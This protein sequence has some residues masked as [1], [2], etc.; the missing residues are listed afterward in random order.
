MSE[1]TPQEPV[2][3]QTPQE[4]TKSWVNEDGTWNRDAM[5]ELGQHSI[6]E[7]YATAEELIKGTINKDQVLGK[8]IDDI[9]SSDDEGIQ[10]RLKEIRG[11]PKDASGYE[12]NVEIPEGMDQLSESIASYKDIF[13]ET[14]IPNE[15]ANRLIEKYV[16]NTV[17]RQNEYETQMQEVYD[18][19]KSRLESKWKN[20]FENN[21]ERSANALDL[22]ELPELAEDVRGAKTPQALKFAEAVVEKLIPL[23][24]D[25]TIIE[26]R[27]T[28][29][30]STIKDRMDD[31]DSR[32]AGLVSTE[33]GR[34]SP[35]YRKLLDEKSELI[36]KLA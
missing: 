4:P 35:E 11:V 5:G 30:I 36:K 7:K 19:E 25:D 9:L 6:V 2:V 34:R 26:A 14:G 27:Q 10:G 20:K 18:G 23:I 8:K 33:D 17:S 1:E 22:L 21:I 29:T 28:Q 15:A 3:E 16:E 12:F 24:E 31:I 13:A 32:L